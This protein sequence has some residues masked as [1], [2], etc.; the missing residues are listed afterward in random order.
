MVMPTVEI[1]GIYHRQMGSTGLVLCIK[2]M[3]FCQFCKRTLVGIKSREIGRVA[4]ALA[5]WCASWRHQPNVYV[6]NL[7]INQRG[8]ICLLDGVTLGVKAPR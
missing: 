3:C 4:N 2:P 6:Q 8:I 5:Q 1:V 7:G